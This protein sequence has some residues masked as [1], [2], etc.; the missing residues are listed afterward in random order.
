MQMSLAILQ[1]AQTDSASLPL[2]QKKLKAC[3]LAHGAPCTYCLIVADRMH[4]QTA[5]V[6][7]QES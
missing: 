1:E 2:A 7:I 4:V 5:I 6:S 3:C